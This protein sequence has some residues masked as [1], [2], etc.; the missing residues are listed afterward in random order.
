MPKVTGSAVDSAMEVM[1]TLRATWV[2]FII[3]ILD[4]GFWIGSALK[5]VEIKEMLAR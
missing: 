3:S 4:F 1:Q 5:S 2:K